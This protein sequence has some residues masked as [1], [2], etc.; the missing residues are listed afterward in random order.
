MK[1]AI[2]STAEYEKPFLERASADFAQQVV[3]I[4]EPLTEASV[5]LSKS[6]DV[7][8]CFIRDTLNAPVLELLSQQGIKLVALRSAGYD[9][10]DLDAAKKF[11]ITVVNA[12]TYSPSAVAEHAALLILALARKFV[13]AQ[14][15]IEK[16]NFS[17]DN[18]LGIGLKGLT[19]GII[20]TGNIGAALAHIMNGFG[21]KLLGCDLV[22]NPECEK[23][24]L[25]YVTHDEIFSQ[26]DIISLHCVLNDSTCGLINKHAIE[27]MKDG[28]MLINTSRGAVV[29][30]VAVKEALESGKIRY[31]GMDVYENEKAI[32]FKDHSKEGIHDEMFEQLR[33]MPNVVI[34]GHQAFFTEEALTNIANTTFENIQ[35]FASGNM[36][37][38]VS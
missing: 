34:T 1:V 27:K 10:V 30:T 6:C 38:Q 28:V 16:N 14:H 11:D 35:K 9:H 13:I 7:I 12:P 2:Y 3:Y 24:G 5:P 19:V 15:Q 18:L 20:G 37:N 26:S 23:L 33:K 17:L 25:K 31:F 8:C 21:C 36:Q 22:K 32:F 29:D 4:S